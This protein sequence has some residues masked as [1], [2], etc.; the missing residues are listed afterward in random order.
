LEAIEFQGM[1]CIEKP[2]EEFSRWACKHTKKFVSKPNTSIYSSVHKIL[3]NGNRSAD[4]CIIVAGP[5]PEIVPEKNPELQQTR[6]AI[7]CNKCWVNI[8]DL[9]KL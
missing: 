6:N 3:I 5:L 1:Q 4:V 2:K 7:L 9:T 8:Y